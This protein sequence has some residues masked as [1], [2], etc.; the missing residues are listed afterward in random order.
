MKK[1]IKQLV[2]FFSLVLCLKKVRRS[3]WIFKVGVTS[4]ESVADHS[5]CMCMMTM[6]ISDLVGLDTER[7]MKM[8]IL[9][10]LGESI[11]GDMMPDKILPGRKK[12]LEKKAIRSILQKLPHPLRAEY[13]T[14]WNEYSDHST[15]LS[16]FVHRLDKLEMAFQAKDYVLNGYSRGKLREF[17]DSAHRTI[18][19]DKNDLIS[20]VLQGLNAATA[21]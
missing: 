20:E 4:P 8:T 19:G 7:A 9:H 12:I 17:I 6:V 13:E 21:N 16:Q 15:D 18:V 5:F 10:D 1:Q 14:I 11:I 2:S 3:G